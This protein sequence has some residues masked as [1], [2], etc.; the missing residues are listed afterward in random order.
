MKRLNLTMLM[1]FAVVLA[2]LAQTVSVADALQRASAVRQKVASTGA[3]KGSTIATADDT[4]ELAY[5][6][7]EGD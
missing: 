4:P 3:P 2:A 6:A 1:L 5:T 7:K